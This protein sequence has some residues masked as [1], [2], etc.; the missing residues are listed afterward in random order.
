MRIYAA[1]AAALLALSGRAGTFKDPPPQVELPAVELAPV[2]LAPLQELPDPFADARPPF[3]VENHRRVQA[4][5]LGLTAAVQQAARAVVGESAAAVSHGSSVRATYV[6]KKPDFDILVRLPRDWTAPQLKEFFDHRSAEFSRALSAAVEERAEA[7]FPGQGAKVKVKKPRSLTGDDD[8]PVDGVLL[9]PF[10]VR[11][12]SNERLADVDVALTNRPTY[13]SD[14]AEYFER[15][16][17]VLREAQGEPGV[18]R[19]LSD[20]RLAKLFFQKTIGAYKPYEGGPGG[21]G[22]EQLVLRAGGF[23]ALLEKIRE[24]GFDRRG[25]LRVLRSARRRWQISYGFRSPTPFFSLRQDGYDAEDVWER[26]AS[27]A[28]RIVESEGRAQPPLEVEF[29]SS[30]RF[31]D[32]KG[33]TDSIGW[34]LYKA[35]R[36]MRGVKL[37]MLPKESDTKK[38]SFHYRAGISLDRGADP[39]RA[40]RRFVQQLRDRDPSARLDEAAS[41]KAVRDETPVAPVAVGRRALKLLESFTLTGPSPDSRGPAFLL[42]QGA[43]GLSTLLRGRLPAPPAAGG[44]ASATPLPLGSRRARAVLLRRGS[45]VLVALPRADSSGQESLKTVALRPGLASGLASGTLVEVTY[46][47]SGNASRVDAVRPIGAYPLDM[48]VGRVVGDKLEGLFRDEGGSL[49]PYPR[50]RL[51]KGRAAAREGDIVQAFVR[52][53]GRGFEAEP[54]LD[55]GRRITPELAAHELALRYGARGYFDQDVIREIEA[56]EDTWARRSAQEELAALRQGGAK[57]EDLSALPFI[58]IDPVGAGDLDDAYYV[59]KHPDG[60]FTWYLASADVARFVKPGGAA[61]RAAARI[62]NT[63]YARLKEWIPEYPMN[64]PVVSKYL[65]SLLAGKDSLAMITRM[66]FDAEGRLL[67]GDPEKDVFLGLVHVRGRYSYDQVAASWQGG[68]AIEHAEQAALARELAAKIDGHDRERGKLGFDFE[69]TAAVR[70]DGDWS[71][72]RLEKDPATEESHRLIEKLK[73]S[74]NRVL[75]ELLNRISREHGVK[76]V[77]RV[78]AP[79]DD[80]ANA[81]LRQTLA[82]LGLPWEEGQSLA[83]YLEQVRSRPGLSEPAKQ[84]VQRLALMSRET[85]IYAAVDDTGHEG[86]ALAPEGYDHPSAQIRRFSDTFNGVLLDAYLSGGDVRAAYEAMLAD[87]RSL[88]FAG[89]DD[90]L[91][92]L[93]GRQRSAK[94][95]S[96]EMDRFL[97]VYELSKPKHKGKTYHGVV[98]FLSGPPES[99]AVVQLEEL[100]LSFEAHGDATRGLALLDRLEVVINDADVSRLRV[101]ARFRRLGSLAPTPPQAPPPSAPPR[102][103]PAPAAP[104]RFKPRRPSAPAPERTTKKPGIGKLL[105]IAG[106]TLSGDSGQAVRRL[107][108]RRAY[109]QLTRSL[110]YGQPAQ[111]HS[112]LVS[113]LALDRPPRLVWRTAVKIWEKL[114]QE[115]RGLIKARLLREPKPKIQPAVKKRLDRLIASS[116]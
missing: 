94:Q 41:P 55:F 59:E 35:R 7:L 38:R 97:S 87:L 99:R 72:E 96:R 43:L 18:Q 78:H 52:R 27:A 100:P 15:Q 29:T 65:A 32:I 106:G 44:P 107:L 113:L 86:L 95:M 79:S 28:R 1:L 26:L 17:K 13:D 51:V 116:S 62:G 89:L 31:K 66:H 91:L 67:E 75:A 8:R 10:E 22:I 83:D 112:I 98:S 11:S 70:E 4:L 23:K 39:Q 36:G 20:I 30:L 85:A 77:S 61:F 12:P 19:I 42:A 60:S 111:V 102:P 69:K 21:V 109:P 9:I 104:K 45:R 88:G 92:H 76:H 49:S 63:F 46:S 82:S 84:A 57:T 58:T 105:K 64:H 71:V 81:R 93:N 80:A 103:S 34:R 54:I 14:Y 110:M 2:L 115:D 101:N 5:D 73:V 3:S 16:L 68:A 6:G 24:I 33:L 74:G 40:R 50:L 114:P 56:L 108:W 48:V 53:T 90:F 37:E 47:D 25:R